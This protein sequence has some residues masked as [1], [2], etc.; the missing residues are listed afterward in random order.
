MQRAAPTDDAEGPTDR[1]LVTC[2]NAQ[3]VKNMVPIA[4]S[5]TQQSAVAS[6]D[7]LSQGPVY[8]QR[9]TEELE[10]RN[11]PV[12]EDVYPLSLS[13]PYSTAS[14]PQ[15]VRVILQNSSALQSLVTDYDAFLFGYDGVLVRAMAQAA[16]ENEIPTVQV[17]QGFL[18]QRPDL[19]PGLKNRVVHDT[20]RVLRRQCLSRV[21]GLRYL[22]RDQSMGCS[23]D[24]PIFVAGTRTKATLTM[25]G[26]DPDRVSVTGVPR[27][28]PLFERRDSDPRVGQTDT[29]EV[30]YVCCGYSSHRLS[31]MAA[32]QETQITELAEAADHD[33]HLTIKTHPRGRDEWPGLDPTAAA[34]TVL[35]NDVDLYEEILDSDLVVTINS[36]VAYEAALL[37]R[38][39]ALSRFPES[40]CEWIADAP[41]ADD[42]PVANN[43]AA[44]LNLADQ[45]RS[46]GDFTRS[47]I[48]DVRENAHAVVDEQTPTA[49]EA[50]AE[51]ILERM[52]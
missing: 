25:R 27:F 38:P 32:V 18:H 4:E 8:R 14:L 33:I 31:Q 21:P 35:G 15:K 10:A 7:F 30:L 3:E 26:V 2:H 19:E 23:H 22:K 29:T 5:I 12:L 13:E 45:L 52:A 20:K 28:A 17:I 44:L 1:V 11:V 39:V 16:I 51:R 40:A 50:I 9:A 37:G 36:T 47:W 42:F 24:G 43:P 49:A 41:M 48:A 6:C 46:D 34:V